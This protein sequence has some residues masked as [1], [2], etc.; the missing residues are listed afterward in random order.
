MSIRME[1]I[2]DVCRRYGQ[3]F[4]AAWNER[5]TLDPLQ[6]THEELAFLPAHL[7]LVDTPPSPAPQW[8]MRIIIALFSAGLLWAFL[9]QLDIVAVAPGKTVTSSRTKIIQPAETSVVRRI[10][11]RDGEVVKKGD[12]LIELDAVGSSADVTKAVEALVNAKLAA[13]RA[14]ALVQAMDAGQP[15]RLESDASLPADRFKATQQLATSEFE[16]FRA[17]KQSL[18]AMVAQKQAEL[19]TV[20]ASI[21]PLAEYAKIA[22]ARVED[23]KTLLDKKYVARQEYLIREQERINAERDLAAQRSHRTELLSAITG[24]KEQLSVTVT[25]TR[26][27]LLDEQR[28]AR[29][30]I[31]QFEP[32]VA[33]TTQRDALMQLHAPVD[34]TVQQLAV[35]TIGGVVTPAQPLLVVVPTQESLEIEAT[36]L[37]KDIGFVQPGQAVT[38]KVESFPYTRYGYLTGTVDSVSH[39]AAQDEKLGLI[40]P[41]RVRLDKSVLDINGVAV[42]MTPGMTLSAE[43]MTGKR[44][45]IDYLLGPLQQAGS[46]SL[47]ER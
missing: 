22:R 33:R 17:K 23:Y 42:H 5:R 4:R 41:A 7:E 31:Q 25:D 27:Q 36:V 43:I 13:A 29:E 1:A 46:E 44:R 24:A 11:V 37:N 18:E 6:R 12:L 19:R 20:D 2:L 3:I 8:S 14:A 28:Q 15:P 16:T 38:V 32:E 10:L 26:R 9:G 34:G 39:D 47:R 21:D 35:H 40:F 45:V 30:Q